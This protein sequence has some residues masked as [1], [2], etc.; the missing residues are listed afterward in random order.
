MP[1]GHAREAAGHRAIQSVREGG[2][3]RRRRRW[4][5][6]T[7]REAEAA[8]GGDGLAQ[9][10]RRKAYLKQFIH[11]TTHS[12]ARF[13]LEI[14]ANYKQFQTASRLRASAAKRLDSQRAYYDEGRITVDR[15]LDAA[16][17]YAAALATEAQYKTTYNTSIVALE[18]AKGT[19]LE[20]E[21]ITVVEGPRLA[22]STVA[23]RD[24]AAK[25]AWR[26][27]SVAAPT[28]P[29]ASP[30]LQPLSPDAIGPTSRPNTGQPQAKDASPKAGLGGK[31]FSF[32]VTVGFGPKPLEIRGSFTITPAQSV[33]APK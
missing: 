8:A 1:G 5:G 24:D 33:D 23:E 13:F 26:E 17:Q 22:T 30:P 28:V 27:P 19:L 20:Y 31:T 4:L 21:Q 3:S 16:S 10:E 7:R 14:D 6:P 25:R 9:L 18:E 29:T 12:L 11:Q 2:R 15:Y 32:Q